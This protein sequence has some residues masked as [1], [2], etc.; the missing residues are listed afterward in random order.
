MGPRPFAQRSASHQSLSGGAQGNRRPSTR[1]QTSRGGSKL[2]PSPAVIS[3]V[4]TKVLAQVR[5]VTVEHARD[6]QPLPGQPRCLAAVPTAAD[7]VMGR[8]PGC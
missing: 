1:A 7:V 5:F 6:L 3:L 8:R 2:A 4:W